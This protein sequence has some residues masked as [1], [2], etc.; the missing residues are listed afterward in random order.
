MQLQ[1]PNT[2]LAVTVAVGTVGA[3]GPARVRALEIFS[4]QIGIGQIRA[5][6]SN[7]VQVTPGQVR[8]AEVRTGQISP[9]F[10]SPS[11]HG[12]ASNSLSLLSNRGVTRLFQGSVC[13]H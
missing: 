6:R 9:K 8:T 10:L 1:M 13:S 12:A 5:A 4:T 11:S 3:D 7:V 2:G